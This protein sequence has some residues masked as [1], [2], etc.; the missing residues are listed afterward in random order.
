M[1]SYAR[2]K[3]GSAR[4]WLAVEFVREF[5]SGA[6]QKVPVPTDGEKTT[7][8]RQIMARLCF[9]VRQCARGVAADADTP[10]RIVDG[11]LHVGVLDV[12]KVPE[13]RRQVTRPDKHS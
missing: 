11:H 6:H 1:G 12:A 3:F 9:V 7:T 10:D 13:R 4:R 8:K 2:G 5:L